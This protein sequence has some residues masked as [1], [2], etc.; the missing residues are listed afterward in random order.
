[1][2]SVKNHL[3]Y[4]GAD[5]FGMG[6]SWEA[7]FTGTSSFGSYEQ[8]ATTHLVDPDT[9]LFYSKWGLKAPD[10]TY[11]TT[12]GT[13]VRIDMNQYGQAV[14]V[15][16]VTALMSSI[17]PVDIVNEGTVSWKIYSE[18]DWL[19]QTCKPVGAT[20]LGGSPPTIAG[21]TADQ[22][23]FSPS[24]TDPIGMMFWLDASNQDP[25]P[26][27]L[28]HT[29]YQDKIHGS[30]YTQDPNDDT[31]EYRVLLNPGADT[32]TKL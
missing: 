27:R 17:T 15:P 6:L 24:G 28:K 3:P 30:V 22:T 25:K 18:M 2:T 1:M 5:V 23:S 32:W 10:T 4:A 7:Y 16:S 11:H 9:C 20:I 21:S 31:G 12:C 26:A 29:F 13:G 8:V 19:D 14:S